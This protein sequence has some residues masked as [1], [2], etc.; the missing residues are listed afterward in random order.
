M[1]DE[2]FESLNNEFPNFWK[3]FGN[4]VRA[5]IGRSFAW[6]ESLLVMVML[7]QNFDFIMDDP[8]YQLDIKQTLTIKPKDFYMR[9]ILRRDLNP[10]TLEHRLAGTQA[11]AEV[12]AGAETNSLAIEKDP[13]GIEKPLSIYYGSNSGTCK[14]F[15]YRLASEV[16]SHGYYATTVSPLDSA[17]QKLPTELPVAIITASYE[18]EP[19]DNARLFVDWLESLG[20]KDLSKVSYAV[21][22]CGHRDW[23]QTFHRIPK[24][25]D[26]RL[27]ELGASRVASLGLTDA[28]EGN[29]L[30]DFEIWEDEVFWPGVIQRYGV[31]ESAEAIS[32]PSLSVKISTVRTSTL[33]RDMQEAHVVDARDFC[34]PSAAPKRHLEVQLPSGITYQAGDYLN[35]LPVNP[36]ENVDRAMRRFRLTW[37]DHVTIMP[38][39]RTSL[40]TNVPIP[41]SYILGAYVELESPATKK[42]IPVLAE[43]TGDASIKSTLQK[44]SGE[45]FQREISAKKLSIFF[46]LGRF[47]TINLPF[48]TFLALLQPMRVR[49][50]SISSS[51]LWNPFH[52]TLTYSVLDVPSLSDPDQNDKLLVCVRTS[53]PS[54]HLPANITSTPVVCVAAGTGLAPFRGFFQERAVKAAAGLQ[55]APALLFFG[56][57]EPGMDDIYRNELDEWQRQGFVSVRRAY[58]RKPEHTEAQGCKYVQDRLWLDPTEVEKLW[59]EGAEVYVCGSRRM[60]DAVKEKSIVIKLDRA[61]RRGM[62]FDREKAEEWFRGIQNSRYATDIFD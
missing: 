53:R 40:P 25:L 19:P 10:S 49:Q 1:L 28:A 8:N 35:V 23:I 29:T 58:S 2:N 46:L 30:S 4:G 48:S 27:E 7:L 45:D 52:V 37:D 22:G 6:Q 61:R 5:C 36:K 57:R 47:P 9:A 15:A 26:A 62:E 54:F 44:L 17:H 38:G 33:Q 60:G 14:A 11:A 3:P 16:G 55:L 21:F 32:G 51:P 41:V 59:Y 43:A 13:N 31:A 12:N 50:Y 39:G 42:G 24:L 18:G 34:A 56:C 20:E